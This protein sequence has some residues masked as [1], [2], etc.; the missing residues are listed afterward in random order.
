MYF[1]VLALLSRNKNYFIK[2]SII[3]LGSGLLVMLFY[4]M[5]PIDGGRVSFIDTLKSGNL[6]Y[7]HLKWFDAFPIKSLLYNNHCSDY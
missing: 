1:F 6:Y 5:F 4:I 2:G 7:S 3:L